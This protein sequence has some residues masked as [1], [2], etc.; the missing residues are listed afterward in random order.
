MLTESMARL[1]AIFCSHN[2]RTEFE[3][4]GGHYLQR[5]NGVVVTWVVAI[6]VLLEVP[7]YLDPPGV[8]FPLD[9]ERQAVLFEEGLT[10]CTL[11]TMEFLFSS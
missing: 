11:F 3:A 7:K 10:N 8:R 9:A 6:E 5:I 1:A 2:S 4:Q